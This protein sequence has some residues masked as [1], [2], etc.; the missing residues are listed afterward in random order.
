MIAVDVNTHI[1]AY[2]W[3]PVPHP[4]PAVLARVLERER[5]ASAWVGHLPSAFWRDPTPGNA[6]LYAALAPFPQLRPAPCVR[7]DWPGWE[8]AFRDALDHGAP[9]LRVYPTLWG[10]AP[11]DAALRALGDACGEAQRALV[12]SVRFEDTRQRHPLDAAPDLS[13]AHVRALAR[14]TRAQLVV[15]NAGREF[16]E[17]VAWALTPEERAR[18]WFDFSWVWGPPEDHFATLLRTLGP[19]RFVYGTGWP[20]RLTQNARANVELLPA[21]LR[22]SPITER[23]ATALRVPRPGDPTGA[24]LPANATAFDTKE[25]FRTP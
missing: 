3:R 23:L 4:E 17:E 15:V 18:V 19:E 6:E 14:A 10:M 1:G 11:G 9:A 24:E 8:R 13:P 20:L 12:V 5:I 21:D 2:P 7:P 22:V 16:I 25:H